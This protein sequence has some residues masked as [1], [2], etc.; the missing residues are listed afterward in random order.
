MNVF[1]FIRTLHVRKRFYRKMLT[2]LSETRTPGK[3]CNTSFAA[4]TKNKTL[5]FKVLMI[6]FEFSIHGE[7]LKE[8]KTRNNNYLQIK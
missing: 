5:F 3:M 6:Q 7:Q 1:A 4:N 2:L 8:R